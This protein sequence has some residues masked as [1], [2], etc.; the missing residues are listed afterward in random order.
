MA[1]WHRGF[2]AAIQRRDRTNEQSQR[3]NFTF[4][5]V[6]FRYKPDLD[7]DGI[8]QFGLVAEEVAKATP[9][10]VGRDEN[11]RPFTV[12]YERPMPCC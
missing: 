11:G 4:K 10:L 6:T 3:S 2:V 8:P 12:R 9:D 5:P 7:P 1:N